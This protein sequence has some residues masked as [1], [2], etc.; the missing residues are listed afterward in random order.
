MDYKV[1]GHAFMRYV[2]R[3]EKVK[4]DKILNEIS[5]IML[6]GTEVEP[7]DNLR[8]KLEHGLQETKYMKKNGIIAAC[9]K[10]GDQ[11]IV[12]T[13]LDYEKQRRLW[14]TKR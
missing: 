14:K 4:Y 5:H 8:R 9:K 6:K 11:W 10:D 7:K 13:F 2:E 3:T 1:T 12:T